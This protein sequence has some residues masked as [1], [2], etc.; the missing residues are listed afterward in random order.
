MAV[1]IDEVTQVI[2]V[3][4][5]DLTFVTGTLYELDTNLYRLAVGAL[6]AS[7]RYMWMEPAFNHN[8]EVTVAGTTFARIIEQTNGYS[9][10]FENLL[11]TA[12]RFL[13]DLAPRYRLMRV[14]GQDLEL[15]AI[16]LD[17]GEEVRSIHSLSGGESFLV[18]L[19]L[20]LGLASMSVHR[21]RVE[22]LF[23]DE[24]FG[25]LDA[26]SLDIALSALDA[27]QAQGHQVGIISHVAGLAERIGIQVRVEKQ[28]GG[29]SKLIVSE[30]VV[31]RG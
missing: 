1:T 10:T 9:L 22:T 25:T 23:I 3:D 11:G 30:A 15:Q 5:A 4:Q 18:S 26:E 14:P 2:T 7:E 20:A 6:L 17:M 21:T 31:C 29:R 28:S 12:N 24:G 19:A 27:L 16:D 13:S 8:G